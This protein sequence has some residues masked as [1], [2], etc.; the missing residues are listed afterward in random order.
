MKPRHIVPHECI[1]K[2][3]SH[4]SVLLVIA[5][6]LAGGPAQTQTSPNSLDSAT[7]DPQ[8]AISVEPDVRDFEI[9]DRLRGILLASE[10]FDP[11]TVSVR[12][13]IVFLDGRAETEERKEWARQLTLRT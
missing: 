8:K 2:V 1:L 11:L 9:A 6:I 5:I 4:L 10:W 3:L 12:E 13:G 7:I